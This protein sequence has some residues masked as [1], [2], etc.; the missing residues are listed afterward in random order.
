MTDTAPPETSLAKAKAHLRRESM[1]AFV[2]TSGTEPTDLVLQEVP[3]P[4]PDQGFVLVQNYSIGL[5]PVDWKVLGGTGSVPGKIPGCDGAG[6]VVAVGP[7]QSADLLGKRVAYHTHLA[8]NGSFAEFTTVATRALMLI[9][10]QLDFAN[11]A[12]LPCPALTAWLAAA[13]LPKRL[14]PTVLVSGAGGSVG[15]YLVKLLADRGCRVT[16]ISHPRHHPRLRSLG[17]VDCL[18]D[19][20]QAPKGTFHAVIDSVG[21][22]VLPALTHALRAN[23]HLIAI[24]GRPSH[25]LCKPFA[26]CWSMHEVALGA[27]HVHGDDI[28]WAELTAAGNEILAKVADGRMIREMITS[29]DFK[30]LP[31]HLAALKN[32]SFSGKAIVEM[33]TI[34]D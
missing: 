5:N 18:A 4:T 26:Q 12:A 30:N 23:G 27:L 25:W 14:D 34:H 20:L 19:A 13:K 8:R 11:A 10:D 22:T 16:T 17:V 29:E 1:K 15:H 3:I 31:R 21:E 28:D 2:W 9:P 32:R 6:V 7:G 33:D 24:Q